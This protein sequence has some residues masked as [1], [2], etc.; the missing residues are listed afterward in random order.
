MS[1]WIWVPLAVIVYIIGAII[2]GRLT[3][4]HKR[5]DDELDPVVIFWP[6]VAGAFLVVLPLIGLQM[7]VNWAARPRRRIRKEL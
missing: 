4:K 2:T 1:A 6:M 7:L 5:G 3:W